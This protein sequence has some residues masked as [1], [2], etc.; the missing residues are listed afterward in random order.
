ML[1]ISNSVNYFIIIICLAFLDYFCLVV[2]GS[3]GETKTQIGQDQ[4]NTKKFKYFLFFNVLILGKIK[5]N[6]N[7]LSN[8]FKYFLKSKPQPLNI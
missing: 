4:I 6:L 5:A 1:E 8:V 3:D 2:Q 7:V